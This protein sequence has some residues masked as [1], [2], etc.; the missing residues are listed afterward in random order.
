MN[1]MGGVV[2]VGKGNLTEDLG[3]KTHPRK[4]NEHRLKKGWS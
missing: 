4:T 1:R 3:K 2:K